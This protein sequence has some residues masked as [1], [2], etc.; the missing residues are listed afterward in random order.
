MIAIN[1]QKNSPLRYNSN[2]TTLH[3]NGA[4]WFL[5]F[6]LFPLV[7]DTFNLNKFV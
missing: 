5:R 2:K 4:G 6:Q 3:Q 1:L 7:A